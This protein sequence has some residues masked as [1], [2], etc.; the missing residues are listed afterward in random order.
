[1]TQGGIAAWSLPMAGDDSD[2]GKGVARA[3]LDGERKFR[4]EFNSNWLTPKVVLTGLPDD[5]LPTTKK[6]W[7]LG[8]LALGIIPAV[9]RTGPDPDHGIRPF[10]SVPREYWEDD[11]IVDDCDFWDTGDITFKVG[12]VTG[13]GDWTRIIFLDVRFKQIQSDAPADW[14][15]LKP[16]QSVATRDK[17]TQPQSAEAPPPPA[18]KKGGAPRKGWWDDLWISVIAQIQSGAIKAGGFPSAAKLEEHLIGIAEGKGFFPGEST[19]KPM[20]QKLFKFIENK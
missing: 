11:E 15:A 19:L 1:M 3:L 18:S 20:S 10:P 5:W 13:Y 8:R 2:R 4:E 16:K 9:A 12:G 6:R 7:L 17:A 14:F